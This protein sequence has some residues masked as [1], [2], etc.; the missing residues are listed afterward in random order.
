[1][2]DHPRSVAAAAWRVRAWGTVAAGLV[3]L[4]VP[5]PLTAEETAVAEGKAV[6]EYTVN[7]QTWR[8]TRRVAEGSELP[9]EG[10]CPPDCIQ[11]VA[12]VR[13]IRAAGELEVL[14]FLSGPAAEGKGVVID[15]RFPEAF[16]AGT[17][18]GAVNVPWA[19]LDPE[20]A[21]RNDILVALGAVPA[22]GGAFDFAEAVPLVLFC[23]G[24]ASDQSV[25]AIRFL[26]EAGYPVEKLLY[27]R[28]GLRDWQMLG[29]S[30]ALMQDGAAGAAGGEP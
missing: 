3:A 7:G 16:A 22:G 20:N 15:A 13:N 18:P 23:D 5:L 8:V 27:Y 29:L 6:F 14:E 21:F 17:I 1:M 10:F 25:R 11:P 9:G 4:A 30:V 28:G 19:T 12:P 24:P 2:W 26:R